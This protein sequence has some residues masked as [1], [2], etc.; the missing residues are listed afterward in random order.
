MAD[1]PQKR[2]GKK[3]AELFQS[4]PDRLSALTFEAAGL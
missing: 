1:K 3:L 2:S 4:E